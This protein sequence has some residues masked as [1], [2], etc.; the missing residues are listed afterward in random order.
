[1]LLQ[2]MR[3][4]QD[5]FVFHVTLCKILSDIFARVPLGGG[6]R[7][8]VSRSQTLARKESLVNCPYTACSDTHPNLGGR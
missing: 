7:P 3:M 8:V 6:G 2:V 4:C 5:V 1:M